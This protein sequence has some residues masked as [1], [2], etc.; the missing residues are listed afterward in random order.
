MIGARLGS[1]EITA[2]LG[3]GGMGEVYRA[4]DIKLHRDVAIK[5]LPPAFTEDKERLQRFEREAQLLAQLHHPNIA[6]IFGLEDSGPT[7]ALVMEL[8]DGPTLAERLEQ[9]PLSIE[10]SLSIARQIA[11]ALEAAHEKGIV[12][13]DLKPQNIK[14]SVDGKVKVLDFGL[15][16]AMDPTG[17]ASGSGSV[18]QL[19]ASPTLTIGATMQG[20]ILGTASYMAPEQAKGFPV[21]KRADIWAFGVVLYEMLA[22]GTL[23]TGDSVGDT[24][25]AVIRK[26]ID[27]G[28]LPEE[29]P[30]AIRRLLRRCLER[31]PKNRLHSIADARIVIDE[32]L[33]GAVEEA[34]SASAAAPAPSRRF[35]WLLGAAG[36]LVGLALGVLAGPSIS[37][38]PE[39][40]AAAPLHAE[41]EVPA[42]ESTNLLSGLALSQDGSQLAFVARGEEGRASLWVRPLDSAEARELP[43]T[44]DARYP[45]WAPDG[46]RIGFFAQGRLKVTD[47]LGGSPRTLTET[48]STEDARGGAWN[49]DDIIL[50]APT[51]TGGM[52]TVPASG[53]EPAPATRIP[54]GSGI[55]TQRFPSF[56][57]DGRR[58]VYY[59]STGTG[60]EPGEIYL[61]RLGELEGKRLGP[62]ASTAV[63]AEPGYLIYVQGDSLV[64]HRFDLERDE[65]V[66]SPRPLG[67]ALP[68]SIAVSGQRSL[69]VSRSG[70][71]VYRAD[72]RAATR[73]VWTDRQGRELETLSD[74]ADTWHYCPT[75]SPD[76]RRA[77]AAHYD[78]GSTS[79]ALWLH[80]LDRG[81]AQQLT[82]DQRNDDTLVAWSPD[83]TKIAFS[84]T[85]AEPPSGIFRIDVERAGKPS[86]WLERSGF[87]APYAWL[88]DGR[89]VFTTYDEA[90]RGS[91]WLLPAGGAGFDDARRLSPSQ[92]SEYGADVTRDGRWIAYQ[93]ES[94]R[95]MEVYVRPL[96]GDR[97][98][99]FRVSTDGGAQPRWR[100]DGRE[101]YYLDMTGRLMAV[102]FDSGDEVRPGRPV[103][104]FDARLEEAADRQYDATADGQRFL[105]NRRTIGDDVPI[106][107]VLGWTER[108][109]GEGRP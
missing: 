48:G 6:S 78:P 61:G 24:L 109:S 23:F 16:K 66:G 70:I 56:L 44:V 39:V 20:V 95:R 81:L 94:S 36:L 52:F 18:S 14:A 83:G 63:W 11:E 107:V 93:S 35:G 96:E 75:I 19:A 65:L 9:G 86:I 45:F 25:A 13:R 33:G 59:T 5:V 77:V 104:L 53:G 54:V 41:F 84:G 62:A 49:A 38:R 51:F 4:T 15:A 57:P 17:T 91:L 34:T 42:P 67:V 55:G 87:I 69:A 27:L 79:G 21:D 30:A 72:K 101:L 46:R 74:A 43:G 108:L 60:I 10:E 106:A 102:P 99:I 71:L 73:L 8:V 32:V 50:F 90:G 103:P 26:E 1:Y 29:T 80:D 2:K 3:E 31:N 47:L 89:L 64:A 68:G 58:Y 88:R 98:E 85:A 28:R 37:T 76:G 105:L 82:F 7:K 92:V 40:A 12:H 100:A 22:G 97:G